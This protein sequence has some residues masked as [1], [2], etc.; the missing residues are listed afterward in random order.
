MVAL[1][2]RQAAPHPVPL[3]VLERVFEARVSDQTAV[4]HGPGRLERLAEVRVEG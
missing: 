1:A 4:A 3:V 2:S